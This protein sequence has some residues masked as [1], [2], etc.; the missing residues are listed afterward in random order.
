MI[1]TEKVNKVIDEL[2][3]VAK[4]MRNVANLSIAMEKS[5]KVF[6]DAISDSEKVLTE[7]SKYDKKTEVLISSTNEL[8]DK[9]QDIR[10]DYHKVSTA[11]ELVEGDLKNIQKNLDN[12]S[13][14]LKNNTANVLN[15][16]DEVNKGLLSKLADLKNENQK[17][18]KKVN[19]LNIETSRQRKM[20]IGFGIGIAIMSFISLLLVIIK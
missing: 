9:L 14:E 20:L 4:E 16:A 5:I 1:D 19:L 8:T 6:E 12:F 2:D 13:L 18:N 7:I 11:V 15:K 10:S 17:L 3:Q